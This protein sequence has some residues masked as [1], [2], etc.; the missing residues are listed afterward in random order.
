MP[1]STTLPEPFGGPAPPEV[2]LTH[3]PLVRVL[4]QVRFP[5]LATIA[6]PS[7]V[8]PFQERIRSSYPIAH[9]EVLQHIQLS[10]QDPEA[11]KTGR[12]EIWRFQ[13]REKSWRASLAPNFLA[14]ETTRYKSRSDFL[15]RM[16]TLIGALEETLNPQ[17]TQRLGLRYIDRIEGDAVGKVHQL[18]KPEFLGVQTLLGD[19]LRH[20]V[21]QA[22]FS[23]EEGA[24]VAARWGLL[25]PDGTTDPTTLEPIKSQS[26]VLDLDM[27]V[28]GQ[29]DFRKAAL[30]PQLEKFAERIY[31]VFR[32]IV[33]EAFLS[34]YGASK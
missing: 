30:A 9:R 18:V 16:G 11:V 10:P 25:P 12:E 20:V 3:A 33:T 14:L 24:T 5:D 13:D 31:A 6:D 23:T 1:Q 19:A 28:E 32:S 8:A 22:H 29:G 34:H 27:F 7:A 2:P 15:K 17:I 26:W 4:A 21:T